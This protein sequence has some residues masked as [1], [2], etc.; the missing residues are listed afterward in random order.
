MK[1]LDLILQGFTIEL[2]KITLAINKLKTEINQKNKFDELPE[3]IN[4]DLA[5]SLKGGCS[6][7]WI[8][9]NQFLQPCCGLNNKFIGG[10][11]CWRKEDV[12]SWIEITD[13]E[14]ENYGEKW[15]VT[16]PDTYKKRSA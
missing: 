7:Q 1:E 4:L 9:N 6:P 2:S 14:L 11:K 10:R 15:N 13:Y 3:W 5:I 16:I 8:K 12:I